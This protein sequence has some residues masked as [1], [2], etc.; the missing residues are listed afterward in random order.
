MQDVMHRYARRFKE[1]VERSRNFE[2]GLLEV[3]NDPKQERFFRTL[4][5]VVLSGHPPSE[6]VTTEGA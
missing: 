2:R 3:V 1:D 4:A 5:H 6:G